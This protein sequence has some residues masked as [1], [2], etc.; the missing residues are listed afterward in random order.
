MLDE[1]TNERPALQRE[2]REQPAQIRVT[3]P[4]LDEDHDHVASCLTRRRRDL[5]AGDRLHATGAACCVKSD[6]CGE[7]FCVGERHRRQPELRGACGVLLGGADGEAE[8]MVSFDMQRDERLPRFVS[9]TKTSQ[10][11]RTHHELQK[12]RRRTTCRNGER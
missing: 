2:R 10:C 4:V 12:Y 3:R 5:G 6:L 11:G 9:S 7:A 8:R 1:A